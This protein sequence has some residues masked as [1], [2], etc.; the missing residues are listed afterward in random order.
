MNGFS[1][2]FADLHV[3]EQQKVDKAIQNESQQENGMTRR[4]RSN[5]ISNNVRRSRSANSVSRHYTDYSYNPDLNHCKVTGKLLVV[6]LW[7]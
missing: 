5:R 4:S 6:F 3:E 2:D 7:L 1:N